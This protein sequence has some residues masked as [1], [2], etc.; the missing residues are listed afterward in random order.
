MEL[1]EVRF[2]TIS[3]G[4]DVKVGFI[5]KYKEIKNKIYKYQKCIENI[6]TYE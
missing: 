1:G 5:N 6:P 2:T 4:V 3:G